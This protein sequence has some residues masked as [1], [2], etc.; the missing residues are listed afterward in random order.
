MQWDVM[1][2]T[3]RDTGYY[4]DR[5]L[6]QCT[7]DRCEIDSIV[8]WWQWVMTDRRPRS[9]S[10]WVR[11]P[12]DTSTHL[13][14]HTHTVL[15]DLPLQGQSVCQTRS[16]LVTNPRPNLQGSAGKK[17]PCKFGVVH[18]QCPHK[19]GF[20]STQTHRLTGT[21]THRQTDRPEVCTS[22]TDG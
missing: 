6:S 11:P 14:T 7:S 22:T 18:L 9:V 13:N 16:L 4:S 12:T 15:T 21:G 5:W 20:A 1:M 8:S 17:C 10:A 3:S 19:G 2:A